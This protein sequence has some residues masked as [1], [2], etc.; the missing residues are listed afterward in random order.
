MV[1][2]QSKRDPQLQGAAVALSEVLDAPLHPRGPHG[3][4]Y[5]T[6]AALRVQSLQGLALVYPA[7][8]LGR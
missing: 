4:L 3:L 8:N 2:M 1:T 7:G 5:V 6:C